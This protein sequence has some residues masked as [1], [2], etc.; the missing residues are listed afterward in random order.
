MAGRKPLASDNKVRA[1]M[2]A[3]RAGRAVDRI[4]GFVPEHAKILVRV[5]A[6]CQPECLRRMPARHFCRVGD[7]P[8]LTH[9]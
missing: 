5:V 1:R 8:T 3:P 6:A 4:F 2:P 7:S 9:V